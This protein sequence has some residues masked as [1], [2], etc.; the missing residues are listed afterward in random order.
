MATQENGD[1]LRVLP[2]PAE[3]PVEQARLHLQALLNES[4]PPQT[5]HGYS[6]AISPTTEYRDGQEDDGF[7]KLAFREATKDLAAASQA[8]S[9]SR[10]STGGEE[11]IKEAGVDDGGEIGAMWALR[12]QG[13]M[14]Y[15]V[16]K[17]YLVCGC[18]VC[19]CCSKYR[20]FTLRRSTTHS[21][22]TGKIAVLTFI[23][24]GIPDWWNIDRHLMS[25]SR[26]SPVG[27]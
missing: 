12:R 21:W 3:V 2:I 13:D 4:S 26:L 27:Q 17:T 23:S 14:L 24:M 10:I 15:L 19:R 9:P 7:L 1:W 5:I 20:Y 18:L 25:I 22:P 8:L 6:S 11:E 16:R